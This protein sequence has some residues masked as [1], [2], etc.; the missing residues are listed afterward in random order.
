MIPKELL[1]ALREKQF[2]RFT[3]SPEHW[4]TAVK[5]KT[6]GLKMEKLS[7]WQ[8]IEVGDLFLMHSTRESNYKNVKSAI[9]GIGV[10]APGL[11]QKN[12]FLWEEEFEEETNKYPLLVPFSE[13]YLFSELQGIDKWEFQDKILSQKLITDLL[14]D[15]LPLPPSFPKMGSASEVKDR[16]I[17]LDFIGKGLPEHVIEAD[18]DMET[19][20]ATNT[21]L[22]PMKNAREGLRYTPTL[23]YLVQNKTITEYSERVT[24]FERDNELLERAQNDHQRVID[25]AIGILKGRGYDILGNLHVDLAAENEKEI[26]LFE[27][28]SIPENK[29][30]IQARHAVGQLYQY[31][32]FDIKE[33]QLRND[34]KKPVH[35]TLLIPSDPADGEYLKFMK[36][37]EI[38]TVVPEKG[39]LIYLSY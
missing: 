4:L 25:D 5:F 15:A 21:P 33:H 22:K 3:G 10:V 7:F 26:L 14:K 6:W 29:F 31:Q 9:I 38:D 35:K 24:K 20:R 27:A 36:W 37:A 17:V 1:D 12:S 28:K 16:K 32:F 30:R 2:Y 34:T 13:I 18:I 39:E 11:K 23:K 19:L 8:R